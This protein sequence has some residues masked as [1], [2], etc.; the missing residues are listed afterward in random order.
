MSDIYLLYLTP[1]DQPT[2][3]RLVDDNHKYPDLGKLVKEISAESD[4]GAVIISVAVLEGLLGEI[5][6]TYLQNGNEIEDTLG[7]F[8]PLGSLNTRADMCF[9]LGL[10]SKKER[11]AIKKIQKIRNEFAHV[12][13]VNFDREDISD[14]CFSISFAEFNTGK[15]SVSTRDVFL[16]NILNLLLEMVDRPEFL[17]VIDR[18]TIEIRRTLKYFGGTN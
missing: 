9:G 16:A 12:L 4:R 15:Q 18:P 8:G 1:A 7:P 6:V 11:T 10:I 2:E 14:R 5:I 3:F 17:R 13:S